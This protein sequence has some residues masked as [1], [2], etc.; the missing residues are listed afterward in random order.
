MLSSNHEPKNIGQ[1]IAKIYK[2]AADIFNWHEQ[3]HKEAMAVLQS[4]GFQGMKRWSSV[5]CACFLKYQ[6]SA[7]N[8]CFN[9]AEEKLEIKI[10]TVSYNPSTHMEH[11]MSWH[12][13]LERDLEALGMLNK[14]HFSVCGKTSPLIEC[15]MEHILDDK[16]NVK[17]MYIEFKTVDV[18]HHD[19]VIDKFYTHEKFKKREEKIW[20]Y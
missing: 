13:Y 10:P 16:I 1:K 17:R 2:S 9:E 12:S 20:S 3:F 11:L 8:D 6:L 4:K 15:A 18:M 7:I 19:A 5:N 14:E